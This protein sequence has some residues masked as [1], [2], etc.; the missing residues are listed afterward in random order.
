MKQNSKSFLGFLKILAAFVMMFC[1]LAPST[2]Q[3]Q[4]AVSKAKAKSIAKGVVESEDVKFYDLKVSAKKYNKKAAWKVTF[5][6]E[7]YSYVVYVAKKNGAILNEDE[8]EPEE[9]SYEISDEKA[10]DVVIKSLKKSSKYKSIFK[11][12]SVNAL[13]GEYEIYNEDYSE[14]WYNPIVTV[15]FTYNSRN[16]SAQVNCRT[17]KLVK[18]SL[19]VEKVE[20]EKEEEEDKGDFD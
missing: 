18:N 15:N 1:I 5:K 6:A 17:K 13:D 19:T 3:V 10:V 14:D 2:T 8:M 4:A 20:T 12:A 11:K 9:V 7:G 16:V